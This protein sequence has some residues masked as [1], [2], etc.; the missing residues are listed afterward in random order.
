MTAAIASSERTFAKELVLRLV[1]A[2]LRAPSGEN[3]QPWKIELHEN[4]FDL[5][6]VPE[7][8]ASLFDVCG[9]ASR[10]AAGA[11]L[12]NVRLAAL[13]DGIGVACTLDPDRR[14][15]RLWARVELDH[16]RTTCS[17]LAEAIDERHTN[18][19]TFDGSRLS[20][21][22]SSSLQNEVERPVRL[23]LIEKPEQLADLAALTGTVD[24]IRAESQRAHVELH[25]WLRWT[26]SEAAAHGD[27]LDV[28]TLG[29]RAH[30]RAILGLLRPWHR[31]RLANR[32][33]WS[34]MAA[35][36]GERLLKSSS[37]AGLLTVPDT[38]TKSAVSL[39]RVMQRIWLRATRLGLAFSPI[40]ALP[41]L[42]LR[43]ELLDGEGLSP[44]HAVDLLRIR[45]AWRRL[46]GLGENERALF[47]FRVGRGPAQ[48]VRAR[49]RELGAVV[50]EEAVVIAP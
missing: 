36:Y 45:P 47:M 44:G 50:S 48:D 18:R 49:R 6:F 26:S 31:A 46:F 33:G 10:I 27:G 43:T 16:R 5:Y 11:F 4:G 15:P 25:R 37:A 19:E 22:E 20:D 13:A 7:R 21:D 39:G 40:T 35:S 32:F 2:G 24:R 8:G 12:E 30:E 9:L 14:R 23:R 29:I 17:D 34:K 42:S 28:R 1:Q 41:L 38:S 3:S